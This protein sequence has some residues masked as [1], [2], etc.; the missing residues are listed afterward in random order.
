MGMLEPKF[1]KPPIYISESGVSFVKA[2]DI[3]Q[4]IKGQEEIYKMDE[5]WKRY[6]RSKNIL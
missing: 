1:N 3:L 4:S 2:K 6:C 5:L